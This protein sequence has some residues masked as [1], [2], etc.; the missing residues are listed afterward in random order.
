VQAGSVV[1]SG[2]EI[3]DIEPRFFPRLVMPVIEKL[4][5]EGVEEALR[6]RVIQA[7]A[8]SIGAGDD[9]VPVQKRLDA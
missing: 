9:A 1:E 3:E 7:V 2:D 4:R 8:G 5:L 6:H